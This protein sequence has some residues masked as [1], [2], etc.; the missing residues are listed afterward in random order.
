MAAMFTIGLMRVFSDAPELTAAGVIL[1]A[2]YLAL[3]VITG[4]CR[5]DTVIISITVA[6]IGIGISTVTGHWAV[7]YDGVAFALIFTFF[8]PAIQVIRATLSA[9]PEIDQSRAA[10]EKM[11]EGERTGGMLLAA[12]VLGSVLII[13][14]YP[15]LAPLTPSKADEAERARAARTNCRG[16]SLVLFWSP[17]TVGMAFVLSAWPDLP[18]WH[19]VVAGL[20]LSALGL[21]LGV[22]AFGPPGAARGVRLALAG[23]RPLILPLGVAVGL[24]TIIASTTT[25]GTIRTV[26]IIMPLLCLGWIVFRLRGGYRA[27]A[28][29]AWSGFDQMGN[30]LLLFASAM[31][32]GKAVAAS[33][34]LEMLLAQEVFRTIPP[35]LVVGGLMVLSLLAAMAALHPIITAAVFV[36]VLQGFEPAIDP[37]VSVLVLLYAWM[38]GSMLALS[39]LSVVLSA[40]VY[41]VSVRGLAYGRNLTFM[42]GL[43]VLVFLFMWLLETILVA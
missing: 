27:I 36:P 10:F 30:D 5:S 33:G 23:F 39:S 43:G 21:V 24:V 4:R 9:S 14:T 1:L 40:R 2:F 37:L 19:I 31:I 25:L 35:M 7:L 13:G 32:L 18:L 34:V 28:T 12:H 11:R 6:A 8:L 20:P 41:N 22:T 26:A 17:F 29:N 3:S 15:I 38:C 42:A 16:T